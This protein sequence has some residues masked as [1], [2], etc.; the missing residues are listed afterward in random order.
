VHQKFGGNLQYLVSGG[1][2]LPTDIAKIYRILGFYV[3]EGYG[4]TECAP[5]ITF[6]RPGEWRYGCAGRLLP[7]CE[8]K[9]A[10]NDEVLVRG[11]NVMQGYYKQPEDSAA[12]LKEGWLHTGD[13]GIIDQYGVRITGRIKEIIVTSNGKNINPVEVEFELMKNSIFMKEIAVFLHNDQLH[14]LIYPE[15]SAVRL[16]S[17]GDMEELLKEEIAEY[18]RNAM[19][20]KRIQQFHIVSEELPKSRLGKVQRFKLEEFIQNKEKKPDEDIEQFSATFKILKQFIDKELN[21]NAHSDDHFEI[22]LAMDSLSKL[23]LL[24]FI[25]NAFALPL[26]AQELDELCSLEK[27][28][29]FIEK[30][31]TEYNENEVSW[32]EILQ[33]EKPALKLKRYAFTNWITTTLIKLIGHTYFYLRGKGKE[34]IPNKPVI[35]VAN[36]RSGLDGALVIARLPWKRVKN[37]YMFAKDKHFHFGIARFLAPRNNII[38]MNINTNLRESL[39]QMSE[40][41]KQGKNVIIFPEGTRSKDKKMKEFKDMFAILSK[42]LKIPILP[43]AISGSER[44]AFHFKRIPRPFTRIFVE[45]LPPVYPNTEENVQELKENVQKRVENALE[46]RV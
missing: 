44:A 42:E 45:F 22:D 2:A 19:S 20:Y 40:V 23:S 12:I 16:H 41:L 35:F 3:L 38:L 43:V 33:T 9:I 5:M 28:T 14:L 25:E 24:T 1:A 18:N 10:E 39:V 13:T 46:T 31:A 15:M 36:H 37:T 4:M 17:D 29:P 7:G 26:K 21:V 27:L 6:T 34:H 32:K 11:N 30:H 8:M